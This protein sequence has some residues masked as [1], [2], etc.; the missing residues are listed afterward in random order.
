MSQ[1][2]I[3]EQKICFVV[4]PISDVQGYEIGHFKRVYEHLLKPAIVEAGY[5]PV[6][7]DDAVKT[8]YIVV[9]I[10]KRIVESE[11]VLCDFS[12]RNPNVMYELGLRHAFNKKVVLISDKKTDRIF[13]IQGLRSYNYDES[14]RVDTVQKDKDEIKKSILTTVNAEE[15]SVN[16]VVQLAGIH[17]API[18]KGKEISPDTKI[19]LDAIVALNERLNHVAA[20]N[21][22]SSHT[23]RIVSNRVLNRETY[24]G[25]T[26]EKI[27]LRS[28]DV[29]MLE[30]PV[31]LDGNPI[32]SLVHILSDNGEML[33]VDGKGHGMEFL[34]SDPLSAR[35]S[36]IPF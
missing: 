33:V 7:A 1:K 36:S 20:H 3:D 19:V 2:K 25:W 22:F 18:P 8:D 27:F 24:Y 15:G 29:L 11:M 10:V 30:D 35:L 9:D 32:G 23:E 4:M 16:S 31:F 5:F 14:L 28:G 26:S 21:S 34:P 12:A 13:D 17:A 6:R